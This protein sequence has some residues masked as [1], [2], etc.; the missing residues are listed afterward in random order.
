MNVILPRLRW[1]T[2]WA[3]IA[4]WVW[5]KV[6]EC[7]H[8]IWFLVPDHE[9]HS[10]GVISDVLKS[11]QHTGTCVKENSEFNLEEGCLLRN[12]VDRSRDRNLLNL[13]GQRSGSSI[14]SCGVNS[15]SRSSLKSDPT[16]S[17]SVINLN[18]ITLCV[19]TSRSVNKCKVEICPACVMNPMTIVCRR[20]HNWWSKRSH[21][22]YLT[23]NRLP[24]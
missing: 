2:A 20:N 10:R 12:R 23:F 9:V 22:T 14:N 6:R 16:W 15:Y 24:K 5:R 19:S 17:R 7:V 11:S 8:G 13:L 18:G 4:Y 21:F 1:R 3:I